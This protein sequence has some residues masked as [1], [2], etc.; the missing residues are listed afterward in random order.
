MIGS[1]YTYTRPSGGTNNDALEHIES[2]ADHSED[3]LCDRDPIVS[4]S[5]HARR[6]LTPP[7]LQRFLAIKSGDTDVR[8]ENITQGDINFLGQVSCD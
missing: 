4:F 7:E 2:G 1:H 6:Q 3:A 5:T 8:D